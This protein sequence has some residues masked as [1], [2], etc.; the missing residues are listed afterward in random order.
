MFMV[1]LLNAFPRYT[2]GY[3][4]LLIKDNWFADNIVR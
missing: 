2:K 4:A 1:A 3:P